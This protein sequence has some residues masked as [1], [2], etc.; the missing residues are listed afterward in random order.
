MLRG[1]GYLPAIRHTPLP[2]DATRLDGLAAVRGL[3]M[4]CMTLFHLAFDLNVLDHWRQDFY[5]GND[6]QIPIN[7][8]LPL[9]YK[10]ATTDTACVTPDKFM[11]NKPVAL[12]R[13]A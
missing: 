2:S 3:A 11:E 5:K 8:N 4:V 7:R 13:Y 12:V 1:I 6:G 10:T 9:Q